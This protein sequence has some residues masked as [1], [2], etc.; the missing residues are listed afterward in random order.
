MVGV[1]IHNINIVFFYIGLTVDSI[2]VT[3][4][5]LTLFSSFLRMWNEVLRLIS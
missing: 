1:Y 3:F 2:D 4:F 5:F